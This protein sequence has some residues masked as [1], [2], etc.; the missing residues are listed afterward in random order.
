MPMRIVDDLEVDMDEGVDD[1][2]VKRVFSMGEANGTRL[3]GVVETV[4][5]D[6]LWKGFIQAVLEK[7][8]TAQ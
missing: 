6:L 8:S 4:D 7:A 2:V 3:V 1:V 5:L